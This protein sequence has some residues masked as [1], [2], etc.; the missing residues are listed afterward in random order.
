MATQRNTRQN[1]AI[2]NAILHAG[3]PLSI[4]EIH[5]MA[6][7]EVPSLGVRTVY[8]AVRRFEETKDIARVSVSGQSDRYESAE[9]ASSAEAAECVQ[10]SRVRPGPEGQSAG[11]PR[12][13]A[14]RRE[15]RSGVAAAGRSRFSGLR[16]WMPS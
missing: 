7:S 8:R 1:E 12:R 3:R 11:G 16:L 4:E 14:A 13:E 15:A 10:A 2:R 9:V 5:E 6:K